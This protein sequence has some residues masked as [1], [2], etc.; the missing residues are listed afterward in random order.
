[1]EIL[2]NNIEKLTPYAVV[3]ILL[4]LIVSKW[5][6]KILDKIPSVDNKKKKKSDGVYMALSKALDDLT[7]QTLQSNEQMNN[8]ITLVVQ[9]IEKT[10]EDNERMREEIMA[11]SK[12]NRDNIVQQTNV[13][14]SLLQAYLGGGKRD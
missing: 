13:L 7:K 4:I 2:M 9:S 12:E 1:M 10:N 6:G 8:L 5:G 3:V 14:T 11:L